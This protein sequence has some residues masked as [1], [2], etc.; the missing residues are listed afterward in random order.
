VYGPFVTHDVCD[1]CR[2][3]GTVVTAGGGLFCES[4]AQTPHSAR[5]CRPTASRLG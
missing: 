2:I 3:A 1:G 5:R 4:T